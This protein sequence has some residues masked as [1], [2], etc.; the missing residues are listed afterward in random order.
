MR[1]EQGIRAGSRRRISSLGFACI[2][3]FGFWGGIAEAFTRTEAREPCADHD[4]ER[5]P[6]FADLHVHSR[7]FFD[8]YISSQR[9]DPWDA[10]RYAK[11]ESIVLPDADGEQNVEARLERRLDFT[12]ITD[13]ARI[14]GRDEYMYGR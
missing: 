9:N 10:Y 7:Y 1:I 14:P 11:G 2:F 5:R 8:S 3:L 13:H 4:A 6:F 12:T